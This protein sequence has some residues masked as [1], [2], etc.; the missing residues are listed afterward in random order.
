MLNKCG[1][2]GKQVRSNIIFKSDAISENVI[3]FVRMWLF[4]KKKN[5]VNFEIN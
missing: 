1:L 4:L 3:T 2:Q 5:I